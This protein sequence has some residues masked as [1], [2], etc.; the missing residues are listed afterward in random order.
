MTEDETVCGCGFPLKIAR[1]KVS[2]ETFSVARFCR[3]A[4][5]PG[6]DLD[7]MGDWYK[8]VLTF[9]MRIHGV[10]KTAIGG[11]MP[12]YANISQQL[13]ST[14]RSLSRFCN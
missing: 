11:N 2:G 14:Q 1:L 7:L 3:T 6:L 8:T 13:P 10:T 4:P 12:A 5:F 9:L